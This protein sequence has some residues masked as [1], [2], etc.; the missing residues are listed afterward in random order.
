M[1]KDQIADMPP[2]KEFSRLTRRS[3]LQS[4]GWIIAAGAFSRMTAWAAAEISPVMEKL[5]TYMTEARNRELP[6]KALRESE[7]HILDTVAAMVSGSELLPGRDAIKFAQNYGGEK[8]ATVVAWSIVCRPIEAALANGQLA[9][10]DESDDDY[11]AG[12]AHPGCAVVPAARA[13][14]EQFGI[15]GAHFMRAV[16]LGYDVGM[17]CMKTL[18]PGM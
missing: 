5:S 8:I 1:N 17:R 7:H 2:K 11:T 6:E 10:S 9:H 4:T 12:G 16:A 15:S 13:V 3:W 14:G 18:G